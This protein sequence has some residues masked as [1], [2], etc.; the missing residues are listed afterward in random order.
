METSFGVR[1]MVE[2]FYLTGT[3]QELSDSAGVSARQLDRNVKEFL[4]SFGLIG[5]GWRPATRY[6]RLKLSVMLLSAEGASI[7]DVA[8]IVGYGSPDAMARAYRDAG[9][10]APSTVQQQLVEGAD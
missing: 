2:R 4:A 6:L 10:A 8:K 9:L 7:T 5:A 3:L 1:P